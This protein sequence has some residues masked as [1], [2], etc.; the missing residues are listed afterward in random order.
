MFGLSS[1]YEE[2]CQYSMERI[3]DSEYW[4]RGRDGKWSHE[5]LLI[6]KKR[7]SQLTTANFNLVLNVFARN[8]SSLKLDIFHNTLLGTHFHL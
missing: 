1:P 3:G 2:A 4:H 6:P 5:R 8:Y 7:S